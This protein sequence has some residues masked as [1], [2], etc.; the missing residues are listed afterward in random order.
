MREGGNRST[1]TVSCFPVTYREPKGESG[2]KI[3][4]ERAQEEKQVTEKQVFML[5]L[6]KIKT[7]YFH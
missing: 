4:G 1:T 7:V 3:P 2:D 6:T 5:V